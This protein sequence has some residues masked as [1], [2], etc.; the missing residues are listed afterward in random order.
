MPI[1][2][3]PTKVSLLE[4]LASGVSRSEWSWLGEDGLSGSSP[5]CPD[6]PIGVC[7]AAIRHAGFEEFNKPSKSIALNKEQV[8]ASCANSLEN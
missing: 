2:P 8:S 4:I 1:V 7:A 5:S 6:H 3:I